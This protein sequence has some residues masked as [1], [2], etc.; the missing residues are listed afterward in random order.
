MI[1]HNTIQKIIDTSEITEVVQDFIPF[2][3]TLCNSSRK[4]LKDVGEWF[5]LDAKEKKFLK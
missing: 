3:K 5:E 2:L 4:Q 1:D